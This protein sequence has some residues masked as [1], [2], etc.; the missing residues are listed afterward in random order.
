M[1]KNYYLTPQQKDLIVC[2]AIDLIKSIK[3]NE[4]DIIIRILTENLY[5]TSEVDHIFNDITISKRK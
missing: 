2:Q 4:S 1:T 5:E 3:N